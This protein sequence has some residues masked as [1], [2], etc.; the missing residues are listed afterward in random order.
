MHH[1]VLQAHGWF[2]GQLQV[3]PQPFGGRVAAS[4]LGFHLFDAPMTG[5]NAKDRLPLVQQRRDQGIEPF[6][7]SI[8]RAGL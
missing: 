4:P 7:I 2:L 3:E 6:P 5:L 1:D 8:Q